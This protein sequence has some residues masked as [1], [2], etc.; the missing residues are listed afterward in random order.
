[1]DTAP[2]KTVIIHG[3]AHEGST[4]RIARMI[5]E[6]TGG[7]TVEFFLPRDFGQFCTGCTACF[8]KGEDKCPHRAALAP[9]LAAMDAANVIILAS[10]VYVFHAT[11]AMK[12]FLDHLGWQWMAHRPKGIMIGKHG[13]CVATAAGAGVKSTLKDLAHS[14]FYWGV[15]RIEKLGMPVSATDWDGVSD[16]KK[17]AIEKKTAAIAARLKFCR[18]RVTP[19][20]K[21]RAMFGI[22]RMVQKKGW[23]PMDVDYWRKNGWLGKERPWKKR[24]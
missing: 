15:G 17:A 6:K 3:Q 23:N 5:A 19:T 9:I 13:V 4:C 2:M 8:T 16:K 10:P 22:M 20:L 18:G 12:A 11:G 1:M 24:Q 21:T 14:L 7:E